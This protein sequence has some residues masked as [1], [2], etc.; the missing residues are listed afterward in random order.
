MAYGPVLPALFKQAASYVARILGGAKA[1]ALPI[2]RPSR[3][4]L[5]INL[6]SAKALGLELPLFLQQRADEVIE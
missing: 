6:K 3:F 5:V 4:E 2:E 1:G